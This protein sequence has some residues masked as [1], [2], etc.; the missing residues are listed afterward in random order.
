MALKIECADDKN[1]LV[2]KT[3]Y[4]YLYL[5]ISYILLY[6]SLLIS[7]FFYLAHLLTNCILKSM[8]IDYYGDEICFTYPKDAKKSQMFFSTRVKSE[9]IAE[10]LRRND[11]IQKCGEYLREECQNLDLGLTGSYCSADDIEISFNNLT[12]NRPKGWKKILTHYFGIA[13]SQLTSN[14]KVT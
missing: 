8:L 6:I 11:F 3:N 9:D 4:L 5:Y 14:A 12:Q 10:T 1:K 7:R 13:L 2:F